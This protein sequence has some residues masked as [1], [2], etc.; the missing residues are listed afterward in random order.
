MMKAVEGRGALQ[1]DT[2]QPIGK[3]VERELVQILESHFL[4]GSGAAG[5]E[6]FGEVR[7]F[8]GEQVSVQLVLLTSLADEDG[9][10]G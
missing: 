2:V 3:Q 6:T 10:L 9:S 7:N 1:L 4:L 5:L 8:G